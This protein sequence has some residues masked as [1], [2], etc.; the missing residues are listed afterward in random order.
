MIET[1]NHLIFWLFVILTVT[2]ACVVVFSK[3]VIYSAFA[4]LFTFFGVAGA[5]FAPVFQPTLPVFY[6]VTPID[7][8]TSGVSR[9]RSGLTTSQVFAPSAVL[10]STLPA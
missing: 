8:G 9:E 3:R 10:K 1:L 5:V 6:W 7:S 4:L 2:S